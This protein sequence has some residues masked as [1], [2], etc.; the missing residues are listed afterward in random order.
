MDCLS[1]DFKDI[2]FC[3]VMKAL[4]RKYLDDFYREKHLITDISRRMITD[5]IVEIFRVHCSKI[6]FYTSYF[7]EKINIDRKNKTYKSWINGA[8]Y[9]EE[10][11][12]TESQGD[13]KYLQY[14]SV[15]FLFKSKKASA[16]KIGCEIVE[17]IIN[18]NKLRF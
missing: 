2:S 16:F 13:V 17:K 14:Y 10:C 18:E 11:N 6:S 8:V 5:D 12:Y 1:Y 15:P 7:V 3:N 9:K 4:L